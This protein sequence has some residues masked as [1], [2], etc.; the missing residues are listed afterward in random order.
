[1]TPFQTCAIAC[2]LNE[3]GKRDAKYSV[4]KSDATVLRRSRA[5]ND[6]FSTVREQSVRRYAEIVIADAYRRQDGALQRS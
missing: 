6:D 2:L 1:M 4:G 5:G 3:F